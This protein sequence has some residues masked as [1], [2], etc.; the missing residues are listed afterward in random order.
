MDEE[1]KTEIAGVCVVDSAISWAPVNKHRAPWCLLP[2]DQASPHSLYELRLRLV[3]ALELRI[4]RDSVA[5]GPILAGKWGH[6]TPW[7]RPSSGLANLPKSHAHR[8]P[9]A[10][11]KLGSAVAVLRF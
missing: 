10:S 7:R 5:I 11:P 6:K 3:S 4:R 1:S 8:K 9:R 2:A